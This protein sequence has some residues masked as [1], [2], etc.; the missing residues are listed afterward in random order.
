MNKDLL[1]L[2]NAYSKH[3]FKPLDLPLGL[4]YLCYCDCGLYAVSHPARPTSLLFGY[5]HSYAWTIDLYVSTLPD[6]MQLA[7]LEQLEA[8]WASS[9]YEDYAFRML[10]KRTNDI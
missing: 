8:L 5:A 9:E 3:N 2:H 10:G 4:G 6:D 7:Y 1:E